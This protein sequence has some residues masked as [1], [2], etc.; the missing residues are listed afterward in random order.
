MATTALQSPNPVGSANVQRVGGNKNKLLQVVKFSHS[1]GS[2]TGPSL[3]LLPYLEDV[4]HLALLRQGAVVLDG[5]DD[6]HVGY[7]KRRPVNCFHHVLQ[8][9][10]REDAIWQ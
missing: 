3:R 8:G 2:S 6:G 1:N 10:E 5:Q 7:D 9:K 4:S